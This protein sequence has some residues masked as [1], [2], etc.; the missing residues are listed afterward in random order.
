MN[1][2][3]YSFLVFGFL[4]TMICQS[5]KAEEIILQPGS[6]GKDTAWGTAYA[7]G[8]GSHLDL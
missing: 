7:E 6:E 8:P 5:V 1:K 3:L 4:L 2:L